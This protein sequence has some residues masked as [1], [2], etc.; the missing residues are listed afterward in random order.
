MPIDDAP[1]G[2]IIDCIIAV[3]DSIS[4]ADD[5][6]QLIDVCGNSGV[7]PKQTIERFAYDL[8]F[9]LNR[10]AELTVR[11][12]IRKGAILTPGTDAACGLADI[13]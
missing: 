3:N 1:H 12:V 5:L 8:E 2:G 13:K 11:L 7:H 10:T 4:K 9:P 6:R